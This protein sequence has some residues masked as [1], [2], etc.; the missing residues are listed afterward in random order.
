MSP[1]ETVLAAIDAANARDPRDDNGEPEALVYGRRMSAELDRLYPDAS[2]RLRIAVRGQHVERWILARGDYP[3]G[4]AGYLAWRRD[5]ARH[6]ATRVGDMMAGAGFAQEDIAQVGRMLRKEG[7]KRDAEVQALEDVAGY[8]FV[9]YYFSGFSEK[10]DSD[11][12]PADLLNIVS[13]TAR[14]M[15]DAARR[16]VLE[17]FDLPPDLATAFAP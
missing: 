14:K 10:F 2:D 7:V 6:H 11:R 5:L 9:K 15:S 12:D 16:R 17:D 8:V 13:R 1:V 3:E 4:R